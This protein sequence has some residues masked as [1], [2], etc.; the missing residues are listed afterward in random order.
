[1]GRGSKN[2][3]DVIGCVVGHELGNVVGCVVG[4]ELGNMLE[5]GNENRNVLENGRKLERGCEV[6]A[7]G[8]KRTWERGWTRSWARAWE[9]G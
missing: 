8:R 9:R 7:R 1:M 6:P 3:S 5:R 2:R 4:S